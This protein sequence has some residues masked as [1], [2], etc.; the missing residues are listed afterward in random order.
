MNLFLGQILLFLR[1]IIS[2]QWANVLKDRIIKASHK[3]TDEFYFSFIIV[4]Q[5]Q[6]R[7]IQIIKLDWISICHLSN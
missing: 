7:I 3:V 2:L 1:S 6:V 4:H 5:N